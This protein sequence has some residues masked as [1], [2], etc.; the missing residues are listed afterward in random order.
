M[1]V[2]ERWSTIGIVY[3]DIQ[4][5]PISLSFTD[6]EKTGL[7]FPTRPRYVP[8]LSSYLFSLCYVQFRRVGTT[9]IHRSSTYLIRSWAKLWQSPMGHHSGG[10]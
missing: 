8:R 4:V 7:V 2:S 6:E 5:G 10:T 1:N 9:F 3:E